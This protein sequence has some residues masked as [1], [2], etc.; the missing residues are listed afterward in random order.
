MVYIDWL[1]I[2]R[3]PLMGEAG[4][5]LLGC[6]VLGFGWWFSGEPVIR[7]ALGYGF[8]ALVFLIVIYAIYLVLSNTKLRSE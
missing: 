7:E 1:R 8:F 5:T 3:N 2:V 4:W 6:I